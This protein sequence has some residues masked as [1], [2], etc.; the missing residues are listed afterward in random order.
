M[1]QALLVCEEAAWS[2]QEGSVPDLGVEDQ[3]DTVTQGSKC[4]V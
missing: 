4:L 2:I 1:E 3:R